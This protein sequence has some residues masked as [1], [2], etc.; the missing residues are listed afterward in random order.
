[1]VLTVN[2]VNAAL[3]TLI[4]GWY[5]EHTGWWIFFGLVVAL[6]GVRAVVF[7]GLSPS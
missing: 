1:M 2:V 3:I 7:D 6:T 4:L 5:A